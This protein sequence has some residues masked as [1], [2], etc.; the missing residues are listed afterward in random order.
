MV[1]D[2]LNNEERNS[3]Q[4]NNEEIVSFKNLD[5]QRIFYIFLIS[6]NRVMNQSTRKIL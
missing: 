3:S 4:E 2:D 5:E 6:L 1:V